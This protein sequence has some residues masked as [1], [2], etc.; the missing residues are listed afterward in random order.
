MRKSNVII[1]YGIHMKSCV[2]DR[3]LVFREVSCA[4]YCFL[5]L[6]LLISA[7]YRWTRRQRIKSKDVSRASCRSSENDEQLALDVLEVRLA[8]KL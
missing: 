5:M 1:Q 7:A 2:Q 4:F 8:N 6:S 3:F